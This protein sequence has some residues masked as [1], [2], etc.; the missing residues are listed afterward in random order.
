MLKQFLKRVWRDERGQDL[1]EYAL[2]AGF[3]IIAVAVVLPQNLMPSVSQ[4]FS[5]IV[6]VFSQAPN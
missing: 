3:M 5:R 2:I 1:I 6:G 4:I